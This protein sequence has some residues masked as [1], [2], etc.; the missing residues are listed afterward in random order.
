MLSDSELYVVPSDMKPIKLTL[1]GDSILIAGNPLD[2]QDLTQDYLYGT[3]YGLA[4][5]LAS[6]YGIYRMA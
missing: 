2:N 1:E 6:L 5:I 3:R 4:V